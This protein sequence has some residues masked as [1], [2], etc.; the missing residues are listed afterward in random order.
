MKISTGTKTYFFKVGKWFDKEKGDGK[1]VRCFKALS[2]TPQRG[3]D[4]K[5]SRNH[6]QENDE[7]K[8]ENNA[9]EGNEEEDDDGDNSEEDK[10]TEKHHHESS[11]DDGDDTQTNEA[12]HIESSRKDET[13]SKEN[14][15]Q[16]QA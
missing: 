2:I 5:D 14:V 8:D 6:D 16:N 3:K 4:Q 10:H 1:I 15:F 7:E 9:G 11:D 12:K 13:Q